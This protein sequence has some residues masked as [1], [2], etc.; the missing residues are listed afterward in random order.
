MLVYMQICHW[1]GN[2]QQM[3]ILFI[4]FFI[5]FHISF[6]I[7]CSNRMIW[8]CPIDSRKCCNHF[9][10]FKLRKSKREKK[11]VT[12][13]HWL[14]FIWNWIWWMSH[15]IDDDYPSQI[16]NTKPQKLS[17]KTCCFFILCHKLHNWRWPFDSKLFKKIDFYFICYFFFFCGACM[18]G[19]PLILIRS[20]LLFFMFNKTIL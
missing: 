11:K 8:I 10:A 18:N 1:R 4:Q 2:K 5:S 3:N 12:I 6:K 20:L 13:F 16:T 14:P 7:Y 9:E 17:E 15:N 19:N